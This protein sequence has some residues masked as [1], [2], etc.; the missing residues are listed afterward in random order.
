VTVLLTEKLRSLAAVLDDLK[1]RVRIALAAEL[2]RA[3]SAAV[4]DVVRAVMSGGDPHPYRHPPDDPDGPGPF[5]PWRAEDRDPWD[6]DRDGWGEDRDDF[7]YRTDPGLAPSDK[8]TDDQDAPGRP[9]VTTAVAAGARVARW[10]LARR[11]T[12]VG[13]VALGLA[14]ALAGLAGGPAVRL[15]LGVL[16]AVADLVAVTDVLG[17]GAAALAAA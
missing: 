4:R 6:D 1:D 5:R 3:V 7:D 13:A 2:A 15:G 14:V 8:L 11:G 12:L 16:G 9:A 10:W 17:G